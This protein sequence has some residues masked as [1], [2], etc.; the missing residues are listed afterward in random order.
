MTILEGFSSL[1]GMCQFKNKQIM[2]LVFNT[3][4]SAEQ[5]LKF[6]TVGLAKHKL[7]TYIQTYDKYRDYKSCGHDLKW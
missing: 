7:Q 4:G 2:C 6:W 3:Y 5:L 1:L